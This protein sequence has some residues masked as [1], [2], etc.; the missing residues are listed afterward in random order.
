MSGRI[1]EGPLEVLQI[2]RLIKCISEEDKAFIEKMVKH[3]VENLINLCEPEDGKTVLHAAVLTNNLDLVSFLLSKGAHPNT[4]DKEG[5]TPVML[6]AEL[7]ND[8]IVALLAQSNANMSLQDVEGKGVLFYC[9]YP[10]KRHIRC[11][12]WAL[13]YRADAN[14]VSAEGSHVFQLMC[15][16]AQECTPMCRIMLDAGADPNATNQKSGITA[17]M[18]AARTGSVPLVRAILSRGGNPNAL[19]QQ[20]FTAVH[21]AAMGGFFEVIQVLSAYSADMDVINCD[22]CTPL[23]YA[24]ASGNAN[25]CKFLAQRGCNPKVKNREGLLP[26]QI[27]KDAGHKAAATELRKAERL[28]RDGGKSVGPMSEVWALKLHDWSN[29]CETE[30]RQA[31]GNQSDTVTTEMFL[32]VLEA[33]RAPVNLEQLQIIIAAHQKGKQGSLSINDFIKGVK[34]VKKAIP[35]LCL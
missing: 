4:Q 14:N 23:H 24:A 17:L 18:E 9:I 28:N 21:F 6:A 8:R 27:A 32:S 30:L 5:R 10:T 20:R 11:L 29:E 25:C 2:Y 19:D 31:F 13:K 15:Q 3:G 1:A 16:K 22:E 12:Q 34:Y 33:L 35:S 26:R 7:G